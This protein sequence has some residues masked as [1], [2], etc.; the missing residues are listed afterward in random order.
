MTDS[1]LV[2]SLRPRQNGPHFPDDIFKCIFL[3]ENVWISIKIS[4]KFALKSLINNIPALVQ[5]MAWRR[6]GGMPLSEPMVVRL[7]MH[8]CVTRPQWVK[9]CLNADLTGV[10]LG[11]WTPE[12]NSNRFTTPGYRSLHYYDA[13][14]KFIIQGNY[15]DK[16]NSTHCLDIHLKYMQVC[17]F[18]LTSTL[19]LSITLLT[20]WRPRNRPHCSKWYF[21]IVQCNYQIV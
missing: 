1:H 12:Y 9:S 14:I 16:Y 4:L 17:L 11:L 2:N 10:P 3:N 15:Q 7:P 6:Q 13:M 8:I 21:V 20:L 19:K 18:T 5:I